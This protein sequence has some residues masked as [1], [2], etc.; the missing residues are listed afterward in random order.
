MNQLAKIRIACVAFALFLGAIVFAADT[1]I[2][3]PAFD[4]VRGLPL[5]DKSFH[6]LLM[7]TLS[8]LANLACAGRR[9]IPGFAIPGLGTA[10]VVIVVLA[11]EISQ[12]WIPGRTFEFYDLLADGLGIACGEF[13]A[14]KLRVRI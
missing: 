3:K 11:E 14:A 13:V 4:F 8:A 5:G 9:L 7:G 12:I 10:I 6:F 1:G 2:A